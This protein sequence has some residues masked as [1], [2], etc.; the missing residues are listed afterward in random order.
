LEL[1]DENHR[2]RTYLEQRKLDER[3]Q[4]IELDRVLQTELDRQN[5]KRAEKIRAE[6]DKR[7]KLLQEVVEGRQQ[8]LID[9]NDRKAQEANEYQWQKDNMKN[10]S[11]QVKLEE[12]DR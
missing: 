9:R 12:A 1:R 11:E 7:A 10:I 6:K 5:A 2:Y 4:Q 8:Q 3:R